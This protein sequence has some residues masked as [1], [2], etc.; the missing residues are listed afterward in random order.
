MGNV[1]SKTSEKEIVS[2]DM[3]V[4]IDPMSNTAEYGQLYEREFLTANKFIGWT[5][6]EETSELVDFIRNLENTILFIGADKN[7]GFGK[8][9]I[10]VV[11]NDEADFFKAP[12]IIEKIKNTEITENNYLYP[13]EIKEELCFPLVLHTWD[14]KKG[15]GR[16]IKCF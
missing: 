10:E 14:M 5:K 9:L 3:K 8:V 2:S 12:K 16:K 4:S 1:S 7:T 13:A 6:A 15:C 11:K